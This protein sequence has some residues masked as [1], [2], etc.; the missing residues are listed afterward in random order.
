[1]LSQIETYSLLQNGPNY[2]PWQMRGATVF[3]DTWDFFPLDRYF[4]SLVPKNLIKSCGLNSVH[5]QRAHIRK[6]WARCKQNLFSTSLYPWQL[7]PWIFTQSNKLFIS[8][9]HKNKS[10]ISNDNHL[11]PSIIHLQW[12]PFCPTPG[13]LLPLRVRH[14]LHFDT[15][16]QWLTNSLSVM[17][18]KFYKWVKGVGCIL[19]SGRN[20]G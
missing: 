20:C 18:C 15:L 14:F 10:C 11:R 13:P 4:C 5:E 6:V 1:M 19:V 16:G 2:N 8:G 17:V 3:S 12:L 9:T 7:S